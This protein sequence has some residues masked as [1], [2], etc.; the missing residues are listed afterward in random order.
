MLKLVLKSCVLVVVLQAI[1]FATHL[2]LGYLRQ[3]KKKSS[4]IKI[5]EIK[6]F[7]KCKMAVL[8]HT[9]ST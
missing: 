8:F 9:F 3:K 6:S 2:V 5:D 7:G 1:C 4:E